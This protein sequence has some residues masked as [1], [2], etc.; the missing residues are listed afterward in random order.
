MGAAEPTHQAA[1]GLRVSQITL[2]FFTPVNTEKTRGGVSVH[3]WTKQ[4]E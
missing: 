1:L 3:T 2:S 4:V